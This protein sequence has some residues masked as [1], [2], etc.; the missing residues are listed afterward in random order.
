MNVI[1]VIFFNNTATPERYTLSLHD[2]LPISGPGG[3]DLGCV[4]PSSFVAEFVEGAALVDPPGVSAPV[5]SQFGWH[6]IEV[7]SFGATPS[8]DPLAI[9]NALFSTD[10]FSAMQEDVLAREV[11]VDP[12]YGVWD[13]D[14]LSVVAA[15]G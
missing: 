15:G 10:E 3:G 1:G 11:V 4:D 14:S 8:E 7:R 9:Q 13:S 12:A 6:V 2:A 5:E